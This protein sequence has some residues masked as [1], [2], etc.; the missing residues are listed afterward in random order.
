MTHPQ[1]TLTRRSP[2]DH[3][4]ITSVFWQATISHRPPSSA[5]TYSGLPGLPT[6]SLPSFVQY[7]P[8]PSPPPRPAV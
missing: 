2:V 4:S 8:E 6:A 3:P 1:P 7:W 5:I